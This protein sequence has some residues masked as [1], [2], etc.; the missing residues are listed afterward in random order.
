MVKAKKM[1]IKAKALL[2]Y[3]F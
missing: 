1:M 3:L 2:N